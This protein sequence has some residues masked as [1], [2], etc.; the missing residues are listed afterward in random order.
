MLVA[1]LTGDGD[2]DFLDGRVIVLLK[3]VAG[4]NILDLLFVELFT[5]ELLLLHDESL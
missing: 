3:V 1:R 5:S 4:R 2:A